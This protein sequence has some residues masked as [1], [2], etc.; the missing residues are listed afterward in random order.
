MLI[1]NSIKDGIISQEEFFEILKEKK[2]C[3]FLKNKDKIETIYFLL[4]SIN[5]GFYY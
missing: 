4:L 2:K 5:N 3:D 1:S